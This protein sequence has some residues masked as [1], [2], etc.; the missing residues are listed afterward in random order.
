MHSQDGVIVRGG[1]RPARSTDGVSGLHVEEADVIAAQLPAQASAGQD[2]DRLTKLRNTDTAREEQVN[3]LRLAELKGLRVLEE[4]RPLLGEEDREPGQVDLLLVGLDL[5]EVGVDRRVERQVGAHAPLDVQPDITREVDLI[6][7]HRPVVVARP[8]H[9]GRELHIAPDRQAEAVELAGHRDALKGITTRDRRKIDLFVLVPDVA[10]DIDA[11]RAV[12]PRAVPQGFQRDGELGFPAA[13][14]D[15]RA[16]SPVGIPVRVECPQLAALRSGA[17][18]GDKGIA[19]RLALSHHLAVVLDPERV[20][21]EDERVLPVVERIEED[22]ERIGFGEVGIPAALA[23]DN[24]VGRRV[25]ADNP[26]VESAAIDEEPELGA[27][28]SGLAFVRLLLGE[29]AER[30]RERPDGFVD[31]PVDLGTLAVGQTADR[32]LGDFL[33]GRES[34][35]QHHERRDDGGQSCRTITDVHVE[36]TFKPVK[37]IW[38]VRMDTLAARM[39]ILAP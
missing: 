26:N 31:A 39:D 12:C 14:G 21:P 22:L 23:D 7:E 24:R 4:E 5:R 33:G 3:R 30:L 29:G 1:N 25:V 20:G 15:V 16:H 19:R 6:G 38:G 2:V 36:R 32:E 27:L 35:A 28:G 8:G 9:V 10:H 18:G 13:F 34:P 37:S 17:A 11:P